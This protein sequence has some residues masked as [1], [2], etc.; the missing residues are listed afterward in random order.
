M[1]ASWKDE[2]LALREGMAKLAIAFGWSDVRQPNGDLHLPCAEDIIERAKQV[3]LNDEVW[4]KL[5]PAGAVVAVDE[6]GAVFKAPLWELMS[7]FGEGLYHGGP[8][9]FEKQLLHFED[10]PATLR[11]LKDEGTD[12]TEPE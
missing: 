7:V 10:P 9:L 6:V 12:A 2:A 11:L 1:T 3:N 4:V 5:T 8:A